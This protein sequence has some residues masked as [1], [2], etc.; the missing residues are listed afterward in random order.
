MSIGNIYTLQDCQEIL[1]APRGL[2]TYLVVDKEI[3]HKVIGQ[4]KVV[5]ETGLETLRE[6]YAEYRAKEAATMEAASA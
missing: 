5:D 6:K 3:P 1:E 2:I 4:S